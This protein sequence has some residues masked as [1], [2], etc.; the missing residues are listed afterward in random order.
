MKELLKVNLCTNLENFI[1]FSIFYFHHNSI[2]D[3]LQFSSLFHYVKVT[4]AFIKRGR[5]NSN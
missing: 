3:L 1:L 4:L 2:L 5:A